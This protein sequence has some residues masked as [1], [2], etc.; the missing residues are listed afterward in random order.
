MTLT[1]PRKGGAPTPHVCCSG[2]LRERIK[3]NHVERGAECSLSPDTHV[4]TRV[5]QL[6]K[7][8]V[9]FCVKEK[10]PGPLPCVNPPS[11]SACTEQRPRWCLQTSGPLLA[12]IRR[13]FLRTQGVPLPAR[14]QVLSEPAVPGAV[15]ALASPLQPP[16]HQAPAS[17]LPVCIPAPSP[18]SP[19]PPPAPG[20]GAT[21]VSSPQAPAE[22][23][24]GPRPLQRVVLYHPWLLV[25]L[26]SETESIA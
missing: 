19:C 4:T 16:P 24:N 11:T 9:Q 26:S 17:Q 15:V 8:R 6:F 12:P 20:K 7:E 21:T 5:I 22:G 13:A 18:A 25:S 1:A 3:L 2:L 10:A 23:V 14:G